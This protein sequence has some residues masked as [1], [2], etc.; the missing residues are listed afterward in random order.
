MTIAM[1]TYTKLPRFQ[2]DFDQLSADEQE[3]FREAVR[4]FVKDLERGR[5]FRPSLRV[6]GVQGAPG[7]FEVTW[8]PDGRA[9]FQYGEPIQQGEP[10]VVWRRVGTHAILSNP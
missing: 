2:K 7:I 10:H 1:P 8:A 4:K 5:G 3:R 9:T 6:K